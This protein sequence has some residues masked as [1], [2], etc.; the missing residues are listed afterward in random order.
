MNI[1]YKAHFN[2]SRRFVYALIPHTADGHIHYVVCRVY[3]SASKY[4]IDNVYDSGDG[5]YPVDAIVDFEGVY[6]DNI[7]DSAT[8][9]YKTSYAVNKE[10][11]YTVKINGDYNE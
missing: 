2:S 6:I 11:I 4:Y 7:F 5:L 10:G 8:G 3:N 1:S 9:F